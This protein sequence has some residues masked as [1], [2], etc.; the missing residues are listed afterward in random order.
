MA[1][2]P[3]CG[4]LVKESPD[5]LKADVGGTRYYFCSDTCR[6]EF[7]APQKELARLRR[8]VGVGGVLTAMILVFTYVPLQT[9]YTGFI[10]LILA[11]PVQFVVGY[12]FY[13]G[14]FHAL[15]AKTSNMDVLVAVGTSAAFGYS[16]VAV[17][18][19]S[20]FGSSGVYFDAAAVIITLVLAGR[21][22]ENLTKERA[23]ESIRKMMEL[24]PRVAHRIRDGS[25]TDVPVEELVVGDMVEVKP[26]E[27]VPTDSLVQSGT[28]HTDESLLT[29]ESAPVPKGPGSQV[30][31][32]SINLDGRLVLVAT[33]VGQDTV[34]G[35][36]TKLVEEA[37][38]GKAPVQRL[39]DRVAEYFV[40]LILMVAV[41]AAAGWRL[42]GGAT[43][44]TSV[45]IFVSVV[46]IACPCALGIATPAA[47]LVGTGNAAKRGILIKGGEAVEA[48]AKVD[49]VLLDK[50]GTITEGRQ[51]VVAVIGKDRRVILGAAAAVESGSEHTIGRAIVNGARESAIDLAEEDEFRSE[52]GR[53]VSGLVDGK[54]VKVGKRDYVGLREGWEGD[55]EVEGLMA[56]G[57]TVAFVR[58][59]EEFG[60][61]AVG[62]KV[63][64]DAE[65][66]VREFSEMGLRV[67]ML[68]GD[69]P[70][71]AAA[72]AKRVGVNEVK[73]GLLPQDKEKEVARY[74]GEGRVVAMVGDGVND[75]PALAKADLGIA[76]G[77]GTDVAKETGGIVLIK[78]RL[79]DA[80]DAV[81]IGKATMRKI[82]QNLL[83]AFGY[84]AVLV[85]I[86]AGLLI[87]FYGAGIYSFLP[88]LAGA[89]MAFSSVSVVS[90]SLLLMRY[91]PRMHSKSN[92]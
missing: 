46:I 92:L 67:V 14:A 52:P 69:D 83:W 19:P 73:A 90:N 74:Q 6:L 48:A 89:A 75:A 39:A 80:V 2:D 13:R 4:M 42:I 65:Q 59:G 54:L 31:G 57:N 41:S 71:T 60:A 9:T 27:K 50:T 49:T 51:S 1:K 40:P 87:P 35:Q 45:L 20:F 3:V 68:T 24:R 91:E 26:G 47:L 85:P 56:E 84:N 10:L 12:R 36:M 32:G 33:A 58:I 8:L 62:D 25:L 70:A 17:L 16:A 64:E 86:A 23:S 88:F 79:T 81:R 77:S 78:D 63:K 44:T 22:L 55:K 18:F 29:G 72:V 11:I 21:L 43:V 38:A 66:A 5:A 28:S 30:M 37:R 53:G 82:K 7:L 61:I 15:R 34:L 76:L